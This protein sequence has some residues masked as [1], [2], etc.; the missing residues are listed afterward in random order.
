MRGLRDRL[1]AIFVGFYLIVTILAT[2]M[3]VILQIIN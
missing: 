2:A 3:E 1:P